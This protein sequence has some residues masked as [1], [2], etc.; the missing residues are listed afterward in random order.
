MDWW[1]WGEEAMAEA[2]RRDVPVLISVGYS[3]CHL[4]L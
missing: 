2:K 1:P 4:C 3:S